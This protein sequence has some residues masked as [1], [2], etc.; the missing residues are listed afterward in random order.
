[1]LTTGKKCHVFDRE[2]YKNNIE[3]RMNPV[4]MRK[5]QLKIYEEVYR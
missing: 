2:M 5:Y 3:K 4:E 1:V